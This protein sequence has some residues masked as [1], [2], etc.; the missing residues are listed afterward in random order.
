MKITVQVRVVVPG[1]HHWPDAPLEVAVLR[2]RHRHL[3]HIAVSCV[4][5]HSNRAV[6]FL[7]LQS[8]VRAH[9]DSLYPNAN[10]APDCYN[11]GTHSCEHIAIALLDTMPHASR[12]SVS[13]DGEN[14][15]IVERD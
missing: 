14:T 3:F 9:L 6:E 1:V 11:F 13:E 10:D 4:A 12:V 5:Q 15:A 8:E 2:G 7:L